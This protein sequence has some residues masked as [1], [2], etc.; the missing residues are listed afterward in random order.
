MN[1]TSCLQSVKC[2]LEGLD[3]NLLGQWQRVEVGL[4]DY[5]SF[6][7]FLTEFQTIANCSGSL[8]L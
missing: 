5:F 1:Q 4:L 6:L 2:Y 7:I 8:Q 3:L